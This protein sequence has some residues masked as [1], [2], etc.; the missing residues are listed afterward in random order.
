MR[1][2]GLYQIF[3]RLF[4]G[5]TSRHIWPLGCASVDASNERVYKFE[6]LV[7][8]EEAE[9]EYLEQSYVAT[10]LSEDAI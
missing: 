3:L 1:S 7:I 2:Q 6:G 4:L 10:N 8:I 5:L 9:D